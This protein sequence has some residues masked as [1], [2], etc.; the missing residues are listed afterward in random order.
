MKLNEPN[1]KKDCENQTEYD[2][3][4]NWEDNQ[5]SGGLVCQI[6]SNMDVAY[7]LFKNNIDSYSIEATSSQAQTTAVR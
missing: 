4:K 1:E 7:P 2:K 5:G 3:M 6:I